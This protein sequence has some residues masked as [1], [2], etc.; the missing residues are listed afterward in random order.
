[1]KYNTESVDA[2]YVE[3]GKYADLETAGPGA[4]SWLYAPPEDEPDNCKG[5]NCHPL[6]TQNSSAGPGRSLSR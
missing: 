5:W 2:I 1:M 4:F 3:S 6:P